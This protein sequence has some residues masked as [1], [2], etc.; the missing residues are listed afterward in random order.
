M[1][2][3]IL[4]IGFIGFAI[5]LFFPLPKDEAEKGA[6]DIKKEFEYKVGEE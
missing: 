2:E 3:I 4:I 6:A 1:I 5:F